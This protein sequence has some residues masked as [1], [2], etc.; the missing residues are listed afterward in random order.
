VRHG[1]ASLAALQR[2]FFQLITAPEGVEKGLAALGLP[3][4]AL[5]AE[6]AGDARASAVERLDVYAGMYFFRIR[7]VLR[8]YFPKLAALLGDAA[9]HNLAVD[10]LIAHP[11]RHPSLRHVG[12]A[13]PAFLRGHALASGRPWLPELA[14]LEHARLDVFDRADVP[15]Q[16]RE[17]LAALAP[18]AFADLPLA[19]IPAHQVVPVQHAV[20]RIWRAVESPQPPPAAP[21]GTLLVWRRDV[22]VYHR[23][24]DPL[25]AEALAAAREGT[26]FGA[27]CAELGRDG[28]P[29]EAAQRAAALLGRWV[30]DELL[31]A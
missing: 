3:R 20:D 21:G 11:S 24:V 27:L 10:Y 7:D 8:D 5:E 19:L 22:T 30:A 14:A 9:F 28:D 29:A 1:D 16:T 12:D 26:T 2:R 4:A 18:A 31:A 15:V 25:E 13:L 23:M 17:A 6:I